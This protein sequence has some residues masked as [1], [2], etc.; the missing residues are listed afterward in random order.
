[1]SSDVK[2]RIFEPFFTTKGVAQ[3]TGLGLAVVH[4]IIKQSGGFID[5]ASEV[6]HGTTFRI[7]LPAV[8]D[9][10]TP[11]RLS[12]ATETLRGQ[13][14]VLL[15][16]DEEAVRGLALLA[17]QSHGYT[18][19]V[20]NDGKEALR[21]VDAYRGK[22]D[23]LVT[24]VVMPTMGGG[25]LARILRERIVGIKILYSSGYTDDSVVRQGV[26]HAEVAFLQKPYTPYT[27][28][29]KARDV[30]DGKK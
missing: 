16:E 19:L 6:G 30:L 5:L 4:G 3:G 2:A 22:I 21:I 28:L 29:R 7:Y 27:L 15:V 26:L 13:E 23:L 20:A 1:M 8:D 9:K 17:F 11:P 25:D 14:T 18:V 10:V 12:V 24:D